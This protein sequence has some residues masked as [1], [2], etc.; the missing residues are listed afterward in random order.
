MHCSARFALLFS[1][2]LFSVPAWAQAP[3]A[4]PQPVNDPQAVAVV[5]A[6]IT[7]LGGATSIS[8]GQSWDFQGLLE[9]PFDSGIEIE[10]IKLQLSNATIVGNGVSRP[11]PKF[12]SPSLFLPVLAA[13]VLLQESQDSNYEMQPDAPSTLGSKPVNVVKFLLSSTKAVAQ[14]WVF[15][16]ST[17]LPVRI[18]FELP[19]Q[20]AQ[21]KSFRGLVD[22]SN[23]SAVSGVQYPFTVVTYIEGM[24]PETLNLK[25]VTPSQTAQLTGGVQ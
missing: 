15:D 2:L 4:T 9:G 23:Y 22:L 13:N 5:Q 6:A 19:A 24:L 18:F 10:T 7:A 25:S 16:T 20:M 8:Q 21:T 11:A 14:I 3:Q 1:I 17:G 12:L